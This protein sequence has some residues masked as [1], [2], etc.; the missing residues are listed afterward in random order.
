A[1]SAAAAT[2]PAA[3]GRFRRAARLPWP[4]RMPSP[5]R[6]RRT[7]T[8]GSSSDRPPTIPA[9]GNRF[10]SCAIPSLAERYTGRAARPAARGPSMSVKWVLPAALFCAAPAVAADS[11]PSPDETQ[12]LTVLFRDLLL[13]NLPDPIVETNHDWGRQ[14]EFTVGVTWHGLRAAPR[15]GDRNDGHWDK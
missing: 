2:S 10:P 9:G 3:S 5:R 6:Q 4:G 1:R 11:P 7:P 14:K 15:R 8:R 12:A 13:K